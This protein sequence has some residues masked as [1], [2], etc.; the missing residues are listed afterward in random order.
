M[1]IQRVTTSK[2]NFRNKQYAKT[3]QPECKTEYKAIIGKEVNK[4]IRDTVSKAQK[5]PS[6]YGNMTNDRGGK[7]RSVKKDAKESTINKGE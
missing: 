2:I 3:Y 4:E 1:E 5:Y 6:T 7:C